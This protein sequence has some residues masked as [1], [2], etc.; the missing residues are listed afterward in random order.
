MSKPGGDG[1][2]RRLRARAFGIRGEWAAL[3]WLLV[4]G[5]RVLARNY[6]MSNGEID[7]IAARRGVIAF[8]E[9]KSRPQIDAARTAITFE[10]RRR[11]SRAV[12]H[13]LMRNTWAVGYTLRGDAIFIAPRKWPE[14]VENVFELDLL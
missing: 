10:K 3:A 6:R 9:V 11:I 5:Y 8:V 14:H 2:E 13:W 1:R 12:T 7:L 4:R